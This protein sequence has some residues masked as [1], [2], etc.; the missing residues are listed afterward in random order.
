[1]IEYAGRMG[2]VWFAG[3][4][5]NWDLA[6]YQLTEMREIQEVGET[7]RPARAAALK[8]FESSFL[9]P[10]EDQIK[11][12]DKAQFESAYRS[13]IQGCNSCHG[14]VNK[15]PLMYAAASLQMEW[16]LNCHRA[17]E[18]FLRPH[19][20]AG[21]PNQDQV[22]N[23]DYEQPSNAHPVVLADGKRFTDQIQLGTYLKD[24]NHVRSVRDITSCNT[25]HR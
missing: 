3:E 7:T 14:P 16:C 1:M 13:A 2:H 8:S 22:F 21:K 23:M 15:M 24:L 17:P 19:Q 4:A 6:Q 12:K 25:C 10:L 20:V 5:A 9:D 11:A 18:K